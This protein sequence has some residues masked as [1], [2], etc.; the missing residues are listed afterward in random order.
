M[1]VMFYFIPE[2][3]HLGY[4]QMSCTSTYFMCNT[5]SASANPI[6]LY[7]VGVPQ[8]PSNHYLR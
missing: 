2:N 1:Y 4:F 5:V 3:R 7:S 6:S 8:A